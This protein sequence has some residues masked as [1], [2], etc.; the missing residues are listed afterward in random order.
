MSLTYLK[1]A[2]GTAEKESQLSHNRALGT[3]GS[4]TSRCKSYGSL[5][6]LE[7]SSNARS[8]PWAVSVSEDAHFFEAAE[9]SAILGS[10]L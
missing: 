10:Q 8:R 2:V 3:L 4:S 1:F 9:W 7:P 6:G 5:G